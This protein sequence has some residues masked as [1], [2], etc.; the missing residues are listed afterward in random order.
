M[1]PYNA[2]TNLNTDGPGSQ[3]TFICSGIKSDVVHIVT[4]VNEQVL[5]SS[6]QNATP[7]SGEERLQGFLK[8]EQFP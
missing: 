6:Q 5:R 1:E 2:S 8:H 4:G 7:K 3:K